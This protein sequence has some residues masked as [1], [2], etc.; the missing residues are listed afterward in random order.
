MSPSWNNR[1]NTQHKLLFQIVHFSLNVKKVIFWSDMEV[2]LRYKLPVHCLQFLHCF[3]VAQV[4]VSWSAANEDFTILGIFWF[5]RLKDWEK[6]NICV[7]WV[8]PP[9]LSNSPYSLDRSP[10]PFA[11][12]DTHMENCLWAQLLQ[13]KYDELSRN[14]IVSLAKLK[15]DKTNIHTNTNIRKTVG[16]IHIIKSYQG[17]PCRHH[18]SPHH[19]LAP[20]HLLHRCQA[21]VCTQGRWSAWQGRTIK[22]STERQKNSR[23]TKL[24]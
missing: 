20:A 11:L 14:F 16:E 8:F 13:L 23:R 24:T 2:A 7:C 5:Q 9:L 10:N 21:S 17:N 22:M 18:C 12:C 6:H 1:A 19:H 4:L 3:R 15:Q